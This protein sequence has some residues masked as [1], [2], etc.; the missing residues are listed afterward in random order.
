VVRA[1]KSQGFPLTVPIIMKKAFVINRK[2]NGNHDFKASTEWID[3]FKSRHCIRQTVIEEQLSSNNVIITDYVKQLNFEIRK[4]SLTHDHIYNCDDTGLNGIA[5]SQRT[6]AS[7]SEISTPGFKT[8][9]AS[10]TLMVCSSAS[11]KHKLSLLVIGK[12]KN[13]RSFKNIKMDVLS[14]HLFS[15][16]MHG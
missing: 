9:K 16:K 10:I 15:H 12:L 8:Q 4:R 7:C 3:K 1:R 11:D 14:V 13:P 6:F 2:L 5:L